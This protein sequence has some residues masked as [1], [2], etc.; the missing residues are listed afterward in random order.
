MI[1][2]YLEDKKWM[3][4]AQTHTCLKVKG[5]PRTPGPCHRAETPWLRFNQFMAN[6]E[7]KRVLEKNTTTTTTVTEIITPLTSTTLYKSL[8]SYLGKVFAKMYLYGLSQWK[9]QHPRSERIVWFAQK[10]TADR[11][12]LFSC[13]DPELPPSSQTV[14]TSRCRRRGKLSLRGTLRPWVFE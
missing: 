13:R 10:Y 12:H 7:Q 3:I 2:F 8:Y 11:S 6:M 1:L 4:S 9:H 5:L 14:S